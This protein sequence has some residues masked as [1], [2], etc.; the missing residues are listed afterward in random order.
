M[1]IQF[2]HYQNNPNVSLEELARQFLIQVETS[3]DRNNS[4]LQNRT[5][6]TVRTLRERK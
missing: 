3:K 6:R 2:F 5:K 1:I 4:Q